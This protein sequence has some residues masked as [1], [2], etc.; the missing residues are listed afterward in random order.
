MFINVGYACL[1]KTLKPLKINIMKTLNLENL[2]KI[3][4]GGFA[5]AF[6]SGAGISSAV[7]SIGGLAAVGWWSPPGAA[8]IVAMAVIGIGCAGAYYA[9]AN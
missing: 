6:C 7:W 1:W 5:G 9:G 4:A 3:E 8:A 2:E